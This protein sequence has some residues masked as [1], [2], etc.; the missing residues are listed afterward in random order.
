MSFFNTRRFAFSL[1]VFIV[2]VWG[3]SFLCSKNLVNAG[4]LPH[5][6]YLL[7]AFISY[8]CLLVLSHNRLFAAS[9]KDEGLFLLLGIFGGSLYYVLENMAL[10]LSLTTNVSLIVGVSP[11]LTT[12]ISVFFFN[13]RPNVWIFVGAVFAVLGL[14][15]L[16]FDGN[17]VYTLHLK[18]DCL[19]L[20]ASL[21]W[22]LYSVL[23]KLVPPQYDVAFTS[24]K[25]F[26]YGFLTVLPYFIS[27]PFNY[28]VS[29]LFQLGV[30][31]N[32]LFLAVLSSFG[33]FIGW[34]FIIRKIGPVN[35]SN[36]VYLSPI[37]TFVAS[38]IFL[39]EPV[40]CYSIIG[41]VLILLGVWISE[42]KGGY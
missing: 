6:V 1:A 22:A 35:A 31:S 7:R 32:L 11:L 14:F 15:I 26:F 12:L 29:N 24:R 41:A 42:H 19:A 33:C 3:T 30:M 13:T 39:D 4:L 27:K 25:V 34:I 2:V 40:S 9:F 36:L 21:A 8:F 17:F 38:F 23:I 37:F 10:S 20:F 5:E 16:V 28:P 18:G